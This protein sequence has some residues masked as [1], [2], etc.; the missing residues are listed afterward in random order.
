MPVEG[1]LI[2]GEHGDYPRNAK[3]QKLYPRRRLFEEV[4]HAFRIL[5][6]RVPVFC[7]KHL[8]YEWL[9]ARWMVR[10]GPARGFPLH[11]RLVAA[12]RLAHPRVRSCR[13]APSSTTLFALG[14]G[15]LDDYGFHALE[16]LQC[17]AERRR[18]GETGVAS[19]RCV[20]G[21]AVWDGL[22]TGALVARPAR[23]A[24]PGDPG[25]ATR[26]PPR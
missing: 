2:I 24:A 7:D 21:A 10:P 8:S 25:R 18:G 5:G 4:V 6:R 9:F 14:Y 16:M 15:D 20:S 26:P 13:S 19:V 3:G 12:G 23:C 22:A 1:V 11:G 17:I